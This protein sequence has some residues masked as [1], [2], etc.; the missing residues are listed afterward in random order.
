M[1]GSHFGRRV[2]G[3]WLSGFQ[4]CGVGVCVC[5]FIKGLRLSL[6]ST[7]ERHS[8]VPPGSARMLQSDLRRIPDLDV[9]QSDPS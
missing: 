8:L 4:S 1:L 7:P 3:S 5:V 2:E 9:L 6:L